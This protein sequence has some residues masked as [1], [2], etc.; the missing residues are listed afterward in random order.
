MKLSKPSKIIPINHTKFE[1]I[2]VLKTTLE[3]EVYN[4]M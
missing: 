4:L 3:T 1:R 2:E